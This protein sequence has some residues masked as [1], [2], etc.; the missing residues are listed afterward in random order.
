MQAF[1]LR[2][3]VVPGFLGLAWAV[4][5]W[6]FLHGYMADGALAR[7]FINLLAAVVDMGLIVF[8]LGALAA[9]AVRR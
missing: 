6:L 4:L 7:F 9:A 3:P 1:R 2:G 8:G 5:T